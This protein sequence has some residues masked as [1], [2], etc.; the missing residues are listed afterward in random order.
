MG[1]PYYQKRWRPAP[2]LQRG[3]VMLMQ[4]YGTLAPQIQRYVACI[5]VIATL[6]FTHPQVH[7]YRSSTLERGVWRC[8]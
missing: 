2:Y 3:Q 6:L 5:R 1:S 8:V 7:E 4:D